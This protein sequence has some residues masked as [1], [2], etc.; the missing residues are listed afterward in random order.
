[1][2]VRKVYVINFHSVKESEEEFIA[3]NTSNSLSYRSTDD[4]IDNDRSQE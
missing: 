4:I 2:R 1:M 3:V